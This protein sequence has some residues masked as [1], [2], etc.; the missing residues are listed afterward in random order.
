MSVIERCDC[1]GRQGAVEAVSGRFQQSQGAIWKEGSGQ[2]RD[3]MRR[4][5]SDSGSEVVADLL[6]WLDPTKT[7]TRCCN[8]NQSRIQTESGR[9]CDGR[10]RSRPGPNVKD[11][12]RL[13]FRYGQG[14]VTVAGSD[15]ALD[16]M[17]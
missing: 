13:G 2:G 3:K 17:L 5:S 1:A 4:K 10:F 15:H 11:A 7:T 9:R 16:E 12:L 14:L 8:S 6:R